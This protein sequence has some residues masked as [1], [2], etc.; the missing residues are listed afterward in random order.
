MSCGGRDRGGTF[1]DIQPCLQL[2]ALSVS[3]ARVSSCSQLRTGR[4]LTDSGFR[5][6][7]KLM[8]KPVRLVATIIMLLSI[9]LCFVFAFVLSS[10]V[11][12][13][14]VIIQYLAWVESGWTATDNRMLWYS[15]SY[16]PYARDVSW[17][18]RGPAD[19]RRSRACLAG[20]CRRRMW[21]GYHVYDT[22]MRVMDTLSISRSSQR[23]CRRPTPA[24]ARDAYTPSPSNY[25]SPPTSTSL[26]ASPIGP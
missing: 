26:L 25:S 22:T 11:C 1:S 10:V 16:I 12:I 15:L 4:E 3:S 23:P 7:W 9:V 19:N 20:S 2:A 8:F 18:H 24:S 21:S 13:V 5:R 14:F 17:L 6:Q